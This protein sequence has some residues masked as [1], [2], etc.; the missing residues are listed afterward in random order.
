MKKRKK[1]KKHGRSKY[2]HFARPEQTSN[3]FKYDNNQKKPKL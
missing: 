3:E 2:A 1:Q